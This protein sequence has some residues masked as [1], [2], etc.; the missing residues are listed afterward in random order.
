MAS[1]PVPKLFF[2]PQP[3]PI[4]SQLARPCRS[5]TPLDPA[6]LT[7]ANWWS[8]CWR[9]YKVSHSQKPLHPNMTDLTQFFQLAGLPLRRCRARNLDSEPSNLPVCFLSFSLCTFHYRCRHDLCP[10]F[11]DT[12]DRH[13]RHGSLP[14]CHGGMFRTSW[15]QLRHYWEPARP[16][17]RIA[18]TFLR[19]DETLT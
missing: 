8:K 11:H 7:N 3:R 17:F 18:Q 6:D 15:G 2:Y 13:G 5:G 10:G 1:A 4:H 19:R 9:L 12:L 16:L 14:K